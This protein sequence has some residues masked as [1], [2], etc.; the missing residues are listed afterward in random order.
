M[1]TDAQDRW[2]RKSKSKVWQIRKQ[3]VQF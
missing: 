1:Q 3:K 2:F